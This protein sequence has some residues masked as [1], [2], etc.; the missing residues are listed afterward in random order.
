MMCIRER[1]LFSTA[2]AIMLALTF[3]RV[4]SPGGGFEMSGEFAEYVEQREKTG[5][6]PEHLVKVREGNDETVHYFHSEKELARY[7]KKN[8]DLNLFGDD[9]S[10]SNGNGTSKAA[11]KNGNT[12]RATHYV[13]I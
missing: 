13:I 7:A 5:E 9:E 4:V 1:F 3:A 8:S 10:S 11:G 2:F 12:R 6:L